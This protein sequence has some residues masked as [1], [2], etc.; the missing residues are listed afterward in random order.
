[1]LNAFS[2][3][4]QAVNPALGRF[5]AYRLE[6]GID[7]F[8]VWLVDAT[9]GRIGTRGH[10]CRYVADD[11]AG[12]RK[13]IR[14]NLRRRATAKQRSGVSYHVCEVI[15]SGQWVK[16]QK[17]TKLVRSTFNPEDGKDDIYL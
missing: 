2:V 11:E 3:S 7:L 13:I 8:G 17:G 4:L 5:R 16:L 9:Y 15:D 12:A 10:R 14:Q 6:A 1:M